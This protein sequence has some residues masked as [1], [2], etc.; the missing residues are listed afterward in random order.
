MKY[1][2]KRMLVGIED[3]NSSTHVL[4]MLQ[5]SPEATVDSPFMPF[6]L[7]GPFR[8]SCVSSGELKTQKLKKN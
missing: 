3:S 2:G 5:N 8:W 7:L 1:S 6:M 4:E